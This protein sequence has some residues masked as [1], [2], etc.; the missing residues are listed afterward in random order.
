MAAALPSFCR[1]AGH[2]RAAYATRYMVFAGATRSVTSCYIRCGSA[3]AQLMAAP[4]RTQITRHDCVE[5]WSAIGEW[6]G[7]PLGL[8]LRRAGLSGNAKYVVFHCADSTGGP[9]LLS[10]A[11]T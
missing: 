5:G 9:A 7:V 10:R 6:S 3:C 2:I 1:I 11:S 8:I 4:R